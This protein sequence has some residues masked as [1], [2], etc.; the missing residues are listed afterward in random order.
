MGLFDRFR[1]KAAQTGS[2]DKRLHRIWSQAPRSETTRLPALYHQTPRLDPVELIASTIASSDLQLFDRAKYRKDP[3][4]TDPVPEHPFYELLD[5]PSKAFPEL[6]GY[7]LKYMTVVFVELLGEFF[8]VKIRNGRKVEEILPFPPAWCI[9]TPTSS[10]ASFLFQPYG[11]TAGETLTISPEDVVWFKQPDVTDPYGRGRGRTEAVGGELDAD[12]M[13]EKWQRNY[14]YNDATPPFIASVPGAKTADLERLR[15]TWSQR[16]GGWLNARK[17]VFL[18]AENVKIDKLGDS[19]KEMDFV[20]SRKYLRDVFLNHYSIP[21]E[22]F[23]IIENSNRSTIDAAYYL[24]AKNVIARRLGFYERII[25]RQMVAADYDDRLIAKFDYEIPED[26]AFSL[27]KVNEG[28][29]R[30]ALTRAD[31]KRAMG[32]KVDPGDDVYLVPYSIMEVPKGTRIQDAMPAPTPVPETEEEPEDEGIELPESENG[33]KSYKGADARKAAHWKTFDSRA[34]AGEGMFRARTRA[35]ADVQAKRVKAAIESKGVKGYKA[36]ID[37]A[38]KGADEAL[39]HAFA[40]AWIASMT[41]GAEIARDYLGLKVSPSFALYN[42]A[43]DAWV[44]K[45][46][47]DKAKEINGTTYAMLQAN[48]KAELEDGIAAGESIENLTKRILSET[49]GVYDNMSA[50]RAEVIARTETMG[51]VNFG[52]Q[53]TYQ[54][55]GIE[56]KEWLATSD[57]DTRDAHYAANGQVVK[58]DEPFMVGGES[59][60]YPGDPSGS[61]GNVIQCRCTILPVVKL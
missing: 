58:I 7:A 41:D 50:A 2:G 23:G 52:Q 29:A 55:E 34:K 22:L 35:F 51:S 18:N 20:E 47:L 45:Y 42:K 61:A 59:L 28:L 10:N 17:P 49:D 3:D 43:F 1:P 40:P 21:P 12:E 39:K 5:Y 38:F 54:A 37:E 44:K 11:T 57:S 24:F 14:Y 30:G 48:L 46:G 31:W 15:D 56:E 26:E 9:M 32:Y 13:A 8:W 19:V 33:E 27:Q 4:N 25:T 16:A 53:V 60:M 36:A 6:D